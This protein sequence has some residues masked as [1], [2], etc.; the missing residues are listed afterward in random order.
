L[1][2]GSKKRK[3]IDKTTKKRVYKFYL[4]SFNHNQLKDKLINIKNF[5][6]NFK[7]RKEN[8]YVSK[9]EMIWNN[10]LKIK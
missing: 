2:K 7:I 8:N 6:K 1:S 10:G 5:I 4:K 9:I 3:N